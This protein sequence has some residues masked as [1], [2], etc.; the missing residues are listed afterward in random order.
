[1][2]KY[3]NCKDCE[4]ARYKART[5][6]TLH[7]GKPACLKCKKVLSIDKKEERFVYARCC[8][9][10]Y[11]YQKKRD[12][13][14]YAGKAACAICSTFGVCVCFKQFP[15]KTYMKN[16]SLDAIFAS[17]CKHKVDLDE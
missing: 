10:N 7:D 15:T 3:Y 9:N 8:G 13:S 5:T 17:V 14:F 11:R 16:S 1:M 6:K 2:E 12:G 4:S